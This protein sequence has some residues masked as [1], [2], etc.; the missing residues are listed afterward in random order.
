[1]RSNAGM[2]NRQGDVDLRF[3]QVS[4]PQ[5]TLWLGLAWLGLA[6][7]GCLC[8]SQQTLNQPNAG[9]IQWAIF[10]WR[11]SLILSNFCG[12]HLVV[13]YGI[14][15]HIRAYEANET[16]L[17][18]ATVRMS[19]LLISSISDIGLPWWVNSTE[20][21]ST[22]NFVN[23]INVQAEYFPIHSSFPCFFFSG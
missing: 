1:M 3:A 2:A 11:S 17:W 14:V 7:L 10:C 12:I 4:A 22:Q 23:N 21:D 20:Q 5:L 9:P 15:I 16:L 18:L 19:T 8:T 6:W 13:V